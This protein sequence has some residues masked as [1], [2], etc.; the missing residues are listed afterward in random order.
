MWLVEVL[1]KRFP[2][3]GEDFSR[4]A[5]GKFDSDFLVVGHSCLHFLQSAGEG[6]DVQNRLEL[7]SGHA[8]AGFLGAGVVSNWS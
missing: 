5:G 3:Q 6:T 1:G 4:I 2:F 7:E 8:G